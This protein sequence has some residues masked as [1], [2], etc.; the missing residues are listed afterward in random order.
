MALS[1]TESLRYKGRLFQGFQF[2]A[3]LNYR[4]SGARSRENH[5]STQPIQS[6]NFSF[7]QQQMGMSEGDSPTSPSHRSGSVIQFCSKT[8]D[9]DCSSMGEKDDHSMQIESDGKP[10]SSRSSSKETNEYKPL[11]AAIKEFYSSLSASWEGYRITSCNF[12]PQ[13]PTGNL[14]PRQSNG[15]SDKPTDDSE[16]EDHEAKRG[17]SNHETEN[18]AKRP[19]NDEKY[20]RAVPDKP[21]TKL[22]NLD[23]DHK[24]LQDWMVGFDQGKGCLLDIASMRAYS[25]QSPSLERQHGKSELKTEPHS[26]RP[27]GDPGKG[28]L[29]KAIADVKTEQYREKRRKNNASAKRSREARKMREIHAQTAAAYLQDENAKLRALVNV[30]KEENVYLREIMLR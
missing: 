23:S 13:W 24:M 9:A 2:I 19:R 8:R 5:I 27:A 1:L 18:Q 28:S 14:P 26:R 6:F 12:Q 22:Y 15:H 29:S 30:L 20:T 10:R 7:S 16:C 11:D 3:S 25:A 4:H 17:K 21:V